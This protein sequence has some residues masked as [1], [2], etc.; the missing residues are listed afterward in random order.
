MK[1]LGKLIAFFIAIQ[2]VAFTNSS[3]FAQKLKPA[4]VPADV[5]GT[6]EYQ[7]PSA[8]VTGWLKDG[9][10]YVASI[11][12]D[13]SNGK[14]YIKDNGDWIRT[15]FTVPQ[16]E[17]PS[18]ITEYVKKNYPEWIISVSALEE[19]ENVKTHYY[20][21]VKQDGIG[22]TPS[23]LT[24]SSTGKNELIKRTDPEGFVDP[25]KPVEKPQ[26][27]AKEPASKSNTSTSA[28]GKPATP[29][30]TK[31]ATTPS[32]P[33]TT[34]SKPAATPSKPAT[35]KTETTAKTTA[36]AKETS[37]KE[38]EPKPEKAKKEKPEV[39]IKDEQGNIALKP[40]TIPE[41]VTKALAK[42][43]MHPEELNW[44][45]IDSMYVAKCF[46]TGKKTAVYISKTGVWDKTL[47]VLPEESVTGP[48]L[49]HLNDYYKGWKFKDAV[50]EQRADKQD[51]TMV[52]FYEKAN[53]KT[54]LVT[55]VIFDKTGKLIKTID[56]DYQLGG[57]DKAAS[58]EDEALDKY[59]E[60][61]NM[62]LESDDAKNVP[63]SVQAV[64]K[65]KYPR[66][67]NVEWKEDEEMNYQAIYYTTR[68]KEICVLNRYGE[69]VANMVQGKLESLS[70][71]IDEYVK[72][73]YK[74]CKV[75]AYY[76]VKKIAEKMTF[77]KVYILNKKTN[78][79]DILW[80]NQ[81]GKPV[82]L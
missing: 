57:G 51:K 75:T 24:F 65:L 82:E 4:D 1:I 59:Y 21:E 13:G 68:G 49:K 36:P 61:M 44:F 71:T 34:P 45:M 9:S 60:K 62:T 10:Q 35:T 12:D 30:S 6:L 73:N 25:T 40:N 70:S 64:F 58:A 78:E 48:M 27:Q 32:K 5:V 81:S 67:T 37:K 72:K 7:Y 20:L 33:A 31:P 50:K 39:V 14:V 46:N 8:K 19:Q 41:V 11:K 66:V 43:V 38:V 52:D 76:T 15:L 42:K 79:E 3:L 18:A 22:F 2:F 56:P 63:E 23:V 26:P 47:T 17:L 55:T 74:N 69:I 28:S 77:Y 29:A 16:G 80:F 53:Y 54:K